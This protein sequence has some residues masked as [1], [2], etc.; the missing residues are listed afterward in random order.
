MKSDK[1]TRINMSDVFVGRGKDEI[2]YSL[3]VLFLIY[4]KLLS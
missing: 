3:N 2:P 4:D 1:L